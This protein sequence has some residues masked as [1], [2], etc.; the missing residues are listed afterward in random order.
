MKTNRIEIP[1]DHDVVMVAEQNCDPSYPREIDIG[2][3]V[4]GVWMPLA[5]VGQEYIYDSRSDELI[6]MDTMSVKV[7][8]GEH[9][10]F[11]VDHRIPMNLE[12]E[13]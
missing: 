7:W 9:E 10:D 6:Y 4:K 1:L 11:I 5:L 12:E 3:Y 2:L 8:D 13:Q